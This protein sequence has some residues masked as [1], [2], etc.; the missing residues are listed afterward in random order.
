ME[1]PEGRAKYFAA[2]FP[3]ACGKTNLAM[4]DATIDGWKVKCVG[5][6]IAWMGFDDD[7]K[8]RA[9]NPENGFF[10]V[11]PGT[12]KSSNPH[13]MEMMH[14]DTVFTNVAFTEEGKVYWEGME[15]ELDFSKTKVITWRGIP[16]WKPGMKN[17]DGR[18]MN[19]AHPNSRFC[20]PVKSC[21][22]LDKEGFDSPNGV[23]IEA[24]L[25]GGRR[26][27]TVPL[28][29]QSFD[30]KHGVMVGASMRSAPTSAAAD[31]GTKSLLNDP[32][33][34]RPFFGY[35]FGKYLKH[36]F[37]MEER[38]KGKMPGIFHVNW[39][40]KDGKKWLWPGFGENS[41]VLEWIF[42]RVD[43]DQSIARKTAIGYLPT[44]DGINLDGLKGPVDMKR[45][46]AVPRDAWLKEES[47]VRDYLV[48]QLGK[49]MPPELLDQL[50][51]LRQRLQDS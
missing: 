48:G 49:D 20:T 41:R 8:L 18:D 25:F 24:I 32:F 45:L 6:D 39:F 12:S 36:W 34:M 22:V 4:M 31:T 5:D 3:S 38:G 9:I 2:A 40:Q 30:W 11:A 44:E 15:E 28:C 23:V 13:A 19:A 27:D 1:N 29:F 35:N 51:Q 21:K 47:E 46:L 14:R 7:G 16:Y 26:P 17:L 10:G 33:A 42:R 43:G 50:E 37:G